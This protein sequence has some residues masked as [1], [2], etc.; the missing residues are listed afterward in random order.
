MSPESFS[1][2][3][4]A[5]SNFN[6]QTIRIPTPAA[7]ASLD[8]ASVADGKIELDFDPGNAAVS[9]SGNDLVF[10]IDGGGRVAITDFFVAG[11]RTLPSLVL[12]SGDEVASA[13]YLANFN[14]DLE[15]AGGNGDYTVPLAPGG[16]DVGSDWIITSVEVRGDE[17]HPVT[18]GAGNDILCGGEG[19]DILFG[20]AGSGSF[21]WSIDE[22]PG[23]DE[24]SR[25][26]ITDYVRSED[27]I[28]LS[29][30]KNLIR[31]DLAGALTSN[32]QDVQIGFKIQGGGARPTVLE[33]WGA[34]LADNAA[35]QN[36]IDE[37]ITQQQIKMESGG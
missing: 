37:M 31:D 30:I 15:T 23:V 27:I 25:D 14:I 18:G 34:G 21:K 9:R 4:T 35:A 10:E 36:L 12:P 32:G 28:D 1:F 17:G 2:M 8:V 6:R 13:D 11:G 16:A 7:G 3:P 22:L 33:G 5:T 19:G 20:G 26:I 24:A 29:G